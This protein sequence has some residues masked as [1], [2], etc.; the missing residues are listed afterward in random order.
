MR[1]KSKFSGLGQ[2]GNFRLTLFTGQCCHLKCSP[3]VFGANVLG[4]A[5][6]PLLEASVR[7]GTHY[8]HVTWGW[9]VP[10]LTPVS[11]CDS[12]SISAITSSLRQSEFL[13]AFADLR[14]VTATFVMFVCMPPPTGRIFTKFDM[15][16]FFEHLSRKYRFDQNLARILGTLRE[17]LC[18]LMIISR[19]ILL[20]MRNVSHK[21]CRNNTHCMFNRFFPR[22]FC[23]SWDGVVN[24]A[25]P[26]ELL[27]AI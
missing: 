12:T 5:P 16:V 7:P 18:A 23:L 17:D 3:V 19:W 4:L 11:W 22:K 9:C 2:Y 27:M 14:S 25:D 15:W 6:L 21:S 1:H 24:L 10:G 26:D 8:P 20:R 13:G